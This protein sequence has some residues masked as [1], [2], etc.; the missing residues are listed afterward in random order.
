MFN[1][2][3]IYV[4]SRQEN[5]TAA[6]LHAKGFETCVPVSRTLH[7]RSDRRTYVEEPVFPGYV[8]CRF[9]STVR[10]PILSTAGVVRIVGFGRPVPALKPSEIRSLQALGRAKTAVEPWPFLRSGER[11]SIEDGPLSGRLGRCRGVQEGREL[12]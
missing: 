5:A 9:D 11:V 12:S 3:A 6:A 7:Q 4:Q 8:F 2:F 10:T 1:W